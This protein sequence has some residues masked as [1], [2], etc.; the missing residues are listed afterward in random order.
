M[1]NWPV[2]ETGDLFVPD[3]W[4]LSGEFWINAGADPL[5][6]L[7][8]ETGEVAIVGDRVVGRWDRDQ[9]VGTVRTGVDRE[10]LSQKEWRR[11]IVNRL[12]GRVSDREA[13]R[14]QSRLHR[15]AAGSG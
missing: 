1:S 10:G 8:G 7:R 15:Q 5:R 12:G 13:R 6:F 9:K 3:G 11:W 2:H 4:R 14:R